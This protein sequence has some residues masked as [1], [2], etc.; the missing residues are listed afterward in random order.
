[1]WKLGDFMCSVS[2]CPV[3]VS[4]AQMSCFDKPEMLKEGEVS[5]TQTNLLEFSVR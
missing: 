4:N 1:M 2:S 3:G 5:E